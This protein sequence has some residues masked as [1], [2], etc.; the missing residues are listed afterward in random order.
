MFMPFLMASTC[1]ND[2]DQIF[3]TL[4]FVHG[5]NVTVLDS[6]T[7]QPLVDGVVVKATDGSYQE[8]L[9]GLENLFIGAGERAGTY[10]I[11]V[12]KTGYQTYTSAPIRVT[13]DVCH[14]IPQLVTVSLV[15]N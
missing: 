8:F 4:E 15:S 12:T 3:C 7:N 1:D 6:Q 14:V 5:L 9:S 2:D 11:T 13:A 10:T